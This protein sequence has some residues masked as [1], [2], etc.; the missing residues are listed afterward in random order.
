MSRDD[1]PQNIVPSVQHPSPARYPRRNADRSSS[2][3][4]NTR[5]GI[6]FVTAV[7]PSKPN[8]WHHASAATRLLMRSSSMRVSDRYWLAIRPNTRSDARRISGTKW[9]LPL[10]I[11]NRMPARGLPEPSAR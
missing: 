9:A 8:R 5:S 4:S 3:T 1:V 6:R 10:P 2:P 11:A 7:T